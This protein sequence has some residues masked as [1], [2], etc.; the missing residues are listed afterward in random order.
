MRGASLRNIAQC[1]FSTPPN[2]TRARRP[3]PDVVHD[4]HPTPP[5]PISS[6]FGRRST[7]N[8]RLH[9]PAPPGSRYPSRRGGAAQHRHHVLASPLA[10]SLQRRPPPMS[11]IHPSCSTPQ[12]PSP[13][14]VSISHP[15][16]IQ[17][18]RRVRAESGGRS[19]PIHSRLLRPSY[20]SIL[21][22]GTRRRRQRGNDS[23]GQLA[24]TERRHHHQLHMQRR[25]IRWGSVLSPPR[26]R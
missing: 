10:P 16:C 21:E 2:L 20:S 13:P 7:D 18:R 24:W 25:R 19:F 15:T 11:T 23:T 14:A 5:T 26:L 9:R 22:G 3:R 17:R 1:A 6:A 4:H 12:T 8:T